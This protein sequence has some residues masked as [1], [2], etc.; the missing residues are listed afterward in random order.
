MKTEKKDCLIQSGKQ[1]WINRE[2][3]SVGISFPLWGNVRRTKGIYINISIP[4]I[5]GIPPLA[6]AAISASFIS[7][8]FPKALFKA[9]IK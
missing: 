4:G 2:L 1:C 7:F 6:A 3:L 9:M 5:S 8:A